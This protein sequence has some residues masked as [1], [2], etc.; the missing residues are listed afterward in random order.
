MVAGRHAHRAFILCGG[1]RRLDASEVKSICSFVFARQRA[2]GI[3]SSQKTDLVSRGKGVQKSKK[4][5][6]REWKARLGITVKALRL[7]PMHP[8][9]RVKP[10]A[11]ASKV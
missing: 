5:L 9:K 1:R 11:K 4:M 10:S 8:Q 7:M 6:S 3:W 2:K